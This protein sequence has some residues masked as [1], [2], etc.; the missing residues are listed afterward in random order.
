MAQPPKIF[1]T[2]K[3][4]HA[5]IYT[6]KRDDEH[7]DPFPMLCPPR[8]WRPWRH[9]STQTSFECPPRSQL[10]FE[11]RQWHFFLEKKRKVS[12][13]LQV[14]TWTIGT[15]SSFLQIAWCRSEVANLR[16][17]PL[18]GQESAWTSLK[19]VLNTLRNRP[20]SMRVLTGSYT[21][22]KLIT[23]EQMHLW[24]CRGF[25]VLF[26]S[27]LSRFWRTFQLWTG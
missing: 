22:R 5:E 27:V 25:V 6:P 7:P 8:V 21:V 10:N 13:F 23:F 2:P 9:S 18:P 14:K 20:L 15:F 12:T 19:I 26:I 11:E 16:S 3:R 24:M 4:D 1:L 17:C